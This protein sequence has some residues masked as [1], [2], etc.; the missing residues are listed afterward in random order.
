MVPKRGLIALDGG[1]RS[2]PGKH[3]SVISFAAIPKK[4][5]PYVALDRA[6]MG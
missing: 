4:K 5:T 2:P 1:L 6:A 3:D